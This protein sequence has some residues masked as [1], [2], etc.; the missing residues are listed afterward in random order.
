MAVA[1][2]VHAH[3]AEG[4]SLGPLGT[5]PCAIAPP[6]LQ[7]LRWQA[8]GKLGK[9]ERRRIARG[10]QAHQGVVAMARAVM[11]GLWAMA[12][13]RPVTPS[14]HQTERA[15][16][17]H[18]AGGPTGLGRDAASVWGS[19]SRA[20]RAPEGILGPRVRQAPDGSQDGGTPPPESRRS[21]RRIWLAPPLLR[22]AG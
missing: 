21:T 2:V 8:H 4:P 12:Q 10:T 11:G 7:D 20:R 14:G 13:Q 3:G 16:T 22:H 18:A 15:R 17:T 1:S 19:P 6:V 5:R 9:R